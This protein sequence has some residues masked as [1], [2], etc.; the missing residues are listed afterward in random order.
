MAGVSKSPLKSLSI[1]TDADGNDRLH[2]KSSENTYK[3]V[4]NFSFNIE[5]L[6]EFP[7]EYQKYNGYLLRVTRVARAGEDVTM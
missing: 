3:S 4:A 1:R 2:V 5:C 6:V 7:R